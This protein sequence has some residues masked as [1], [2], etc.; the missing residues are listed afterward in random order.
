MIRRDKREHRIASTNKYRGVEQLGSSLG[1]RAKTIEY[2]FCEVIPH[3]ARS[4]QASL[5]SEEND[6][7][8][9]AA[10]SDN[11]E[12]YEMR[13]EAPSRNLISRGRAAW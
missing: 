10:R 4:F 2:R 13:G 12:G 3:E 1:E 7:A 11:P 5:R 9:A 6:Y 8:P